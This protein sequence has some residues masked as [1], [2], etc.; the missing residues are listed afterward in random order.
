MSPILSK[1]ACEP[2]ADE[3]GR[4]VNQ[5]PRALSPISET[6]SRER[7][8]TAFD[9]TARDLCELA[10]E[11]LATVASRVEA[12]EDWG[13]QERAPGVAD[14]GSCKLAPPRCL[15]WGHIWLP[16]LCHLFNFV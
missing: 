16:S 1:P 8:E 4:A 5:A 10:A 7:P 12:C 15:A 14:R 11:T 3:T 13:I 2:S 9:V 6:E